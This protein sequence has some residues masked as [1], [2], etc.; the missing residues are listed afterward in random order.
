MSYRKINLRDIAFRISFSPVYFQH[1]LECF[2]SE[3]PEPLDHTYF[4]TD[5]DQLHGPIFFPDTI[6]VFIKFPETSSFC[7]QSISFQQQI[8]DH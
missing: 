6:K 1:P 5:E 7:L 8:I 3:I 4:R 2:Q